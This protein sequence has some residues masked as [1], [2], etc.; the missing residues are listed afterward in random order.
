MGGSSTHRLPVRTQERP[1]SGKL[2]HTTPEGAFYC[3]SCV[4]SCFMSSD[5]WQSDVLLLNP[6]GLPACSATPY[7]VLCPQVVPFFGDLVCRQLAFQAQAF[8][9]RA[10]R[11]TGGSAERETCS[12]TFRNPKSG[13]YLHAI[14][15]E[16]LFPVNRASFDAL[17]SISLFTSSSVTGSQKVKGQH[18]A[19]M[20]G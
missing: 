13:S 6:P 4:S 8:E 10:G 7:L 16:F 9:D 14:L 18:P 2:V 15:A 1:V 12:G 11:N 17:N 19:A 20:V 5:W 3:E